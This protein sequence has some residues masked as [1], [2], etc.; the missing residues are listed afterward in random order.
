MKDVV[1]RVIRG[2]L[3]RQLNHLYQRRI[4][5]VET[6]SYSRKTKISFTILYRSP[7]SLI[8]FIA[9][10]PIKDDDD[11][12]GILNLGEVIAKHASHKSIELIKCRVTTADV[13]FFKAVSPECFQKYLNQLHSNKAVGHDGIHG[14]FLKLSGSHLTNNLCNLLN[15]CVISNCFPSQMKLADVTPLFK[16]DDTLSKENSDQ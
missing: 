9:P 11:S 5:V 16:K 3:I 7:I 2:P 10:F 6:E 12:L 13:F 4:R 8:V 1:H 14:K 15:T